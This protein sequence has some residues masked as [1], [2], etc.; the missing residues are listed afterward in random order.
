MKTLDDFNEKNKWLKPNKNQSLEFFFV[1][2]SL[3]LNRDSHS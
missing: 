3:H 2:S 1:Y